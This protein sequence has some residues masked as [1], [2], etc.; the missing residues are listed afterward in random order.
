MS[1]STRVIA[2]L[3]MLLPIALLSRAEPVGPVSAATRSGPQEVDQDSVDAYIRAGMHTAHIPGLALGVVLG[4]RVAYLKG[5]GIAGPDGRPVTS[6]TP[7]I[8][9]STS[10]SFTALAVM[11]LVE[12]GKIDLD[13]P[14]T[15]YLPWFR[16]SHAAAS[17]QITVRNLL[18]QDSGLPAYEGRRGLS[19]NDQSSAALEKGIRE[20]SR[21]QLSQPAG[22]RYE[23]ANENYNILGLIV[24]TVSGTPYE[25]YIR[26]EI[27]APLQMRHSAAARSDP[28]ITD[29]ATGYRS[30]LFWPV[31]FDAPFPRRATPAGSLMSSAEDMAHYLTAQLNGGAYLDNQ[32]L[33]P[34]GMVTL[35]T[36]GARMGPSSSYG[37]GWVIQ[38]QPG[39]TRVWHNGDESNF[40]SNLLLLPDQHIGIV[41]LMNVGGFFKSSAF[42]D[43]IEGVAAILLGHGLTASSNPP[44]TVLSQVMLLTA[45]LVPILWI[46]W[47]YRSIRRWRHRGELP[48][49]GISLVWRFCVPLI[50]DLCPVGLAWVLVPARFHTPMETIALFAPDAFLVIATITA[51]SLGWATARTFFTLNTRRVM[52]DAIS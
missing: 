40:H 19:D 7:F 9:G 25:D 6:Q 29:I 23:Y 38:G 2:A 15:T 28:A 50:I 12:A 42:N 46:A 3:A 13:A 11:Q 8:L 48:P 43:P 32:L 21:V 51:L 18:H 41:V 36:P 1:H 39:S 33:S 35:H 22:Q 30:W 26:F 16:T 5:Y 45:L 14:V 34:Q 24:Q 10:K 52:N 44:S 37:M 27:F 17:A 49:R 47:S 31:A 4:N 20:L